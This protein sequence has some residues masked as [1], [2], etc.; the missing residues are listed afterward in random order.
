MKWIRLCIFTLTILA[1]AGICSCSSDDD[2]DQKEEK[3]DP[4]SP[5]TLQEQKDRL[6][7]TVRSLTGAILAD[8]IQWSLDDDANCTLSIN[9]KDQ[10]TVSGTIS[11]A[12][13]F[14]ACMDEM[15]RSRNNETA[16]KAALNKANSLL[17]LNVYL[18]GNAE[19]LASIVLIASVERTPWNGEE[20][21]TA[22]PAVVFS[23]GTSYT[24]TQYI[25]SEESSLLTERIKEF[26]ETLKKEVAN[27]V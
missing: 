4:T 14:Y 16:F 8:D 25:D 2:K 5:L 15:E 12:Y 10:A 1:T 24:I 20:T 19:P 17:H 21:W 23:D 26:F 7:Q 22:L 9:V 13:I 6:E 3:P 27:H 11:Q 18:A